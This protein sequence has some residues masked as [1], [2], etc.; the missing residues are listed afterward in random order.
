MYRQNSWTNSITNPT[1]LHTIGTTP[2][3]SI[4]MTWSNDSGCYMLPKACRCRNLSTD[5]TLL[6]LW[7]KI[8]MIHWTPNT[9]RVDFPVSQWQWLKGSKR[10]K[11][12]ANP[13]AMTLTA[14]VIKPQIPKRVKQDAHS[15]WL[16]HYSTVFTIEENL[17]QDLMLCTLVRH[18]DACLSEHHM[19]LDPPEV[20]E[21]LTLCHM[22]NGWVAYTTVQ[23]CL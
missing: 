4:L 15:A 22:W 18:E 10:P 8:C 13:W 6:N 5:G 21:R 17:A 9:L 2:M 19:S 1:Y 3:I 23:L 7:K 16:R 14:K 12:I 11:L 20:N